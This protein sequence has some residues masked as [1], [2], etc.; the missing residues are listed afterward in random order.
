MHVCVCVCVCVCMCVCV[1]VCVSPCV[2]VCHCVCVCVCVHACACAWC[3][4]ATNRDDQMF[5]EL[6]V[7]SKNILHFFE[8]H[9]QWNSP[10]WILD[11]L[12]PHQNIIECV[13]NCCNKI[14]F[15]SV[16]GYAGCLTLV[17]C[18]RQHVGVQ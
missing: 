5:G 2:C 13:F 17:R 12:K 1:C 11:K 16:Y 6:N 18:R 7:V 3:V 8:E 10:N 9:A 14:H 4:V 15:P